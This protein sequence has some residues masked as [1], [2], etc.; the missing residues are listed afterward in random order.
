MNTKTLSPRALS[1]IDQ[2]LHFKVGPAMCS[3]PYFNNRTTRARVA[4]RAHTGKGSPKD[5]FDEAQSVLLKAHVATDSLT[6]ESL[7]KLLVDNNLGIDCSG[8]AY[9]VL[10]SESVETSTG[11]LDTR[12][13]FVNAGGLLGKIRAKLRPVE[14][15]SVA[16][17]ANNKNS[18]V[19]ELKDIVPGDM[20][21]LLATQSKTPSIPNTTPPQPHQNDRDHILVIHQVE[22]QN[23]VASK[24]HYSHAVAYPEDGI[25]GSGIKQ[26]VI[27]IV[28]HTK[29][30]TEALWIEND[31]EGPSNRI[32]TRAQNSKT[33]ARRLK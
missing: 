30:I 20:I 25:Y 32:F 12:I 11:K 2:Y 29:P 14:N 15:C 21:T 7:K 22:Y 8:F 19:V 18:T 5:I 27:E 28:D 31:R 26:G 23:F 4:L 13:S 1:V 24:I 9:Y 33:E 17:L 16:T 3:V 10:N 6:S